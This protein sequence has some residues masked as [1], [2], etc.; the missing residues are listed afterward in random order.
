MVL[1]PSTIFDLPGEERQLPSGHLH[2]VS[3]MQTSDQT[4]CHRM[5]PPRALHPEM[6]YILILNPPGLSR[7]MLQPVT[8]SGDQCTG[9]SAHWPGLAPDLQIAARSLWKPFCYSLTCLS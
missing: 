4:K 7:G 6:H 1:E 5:L 8:L 2:S 3:G 9:V